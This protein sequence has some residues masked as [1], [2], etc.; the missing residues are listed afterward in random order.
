M[1]KAYTFHDVVALNLTGCPTV[2]MHPKTARRLAKQLVNHAQGVERG[3]WRDSSE[4]DGI[5]MSSDQ[6]RRD[7]MDSIRYIRDKTQINT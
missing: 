5:V 6:T 7:G 1:S 4:L 2:Y 3:E